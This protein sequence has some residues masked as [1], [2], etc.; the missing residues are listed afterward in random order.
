M[1]HSYYYLILIIFKYNNYFKN[2]L[3][4][5]FSYFYVSQYLQNLLISMKLSTYNLNN[6]YLCN[7]E[8]VL[9][10]YFFN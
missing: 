8:M 6:N 5:F 9:T 10:I 2:V 1:G 3:K 4:P 7:Y